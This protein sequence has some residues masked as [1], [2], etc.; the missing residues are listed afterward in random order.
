[1]LRELDPQAYEN[2][3]AM[4][5]EFDYSL[6]IRAALAGNSP[7]RIFVDH[8]DHPKVAFA[9][10][11]EGYLLGGDCE[12]PACRSSVQ[13]FWQEQVFTGKVY[14]DDAT[15]MSLAVHPAGWEHWLPVLIPTHEVEK[16]D[17]YHYLCN[18]LCFDWRSS[19]PSGYIVRRFDRSLLDDPA[20]NLGDSI[21]DFD[22]IDIH[23][24]SLDH[25]LTSGVGFCVLTGNQVASWCQ[26]DCAAGNQID[27]GIE[28]HPQH[29]RRGLATIATAATVEYCL[30]NGYQAVG[31]HCNAINQA[32]W[33]TAQ[34]VGF[35]RDR[36]YAY[37][38][39]MFD[40]LDHL[41]E[42]GWFFYQRGDHEK[43]RQYYE[44]VFSARQDN[45]VEYY[46]LAARVWA[47]VGE[48][49]KA[50]EYLSAAAQRGCTDYEHTRSVEAYK[51]LHATTAWSTILKQMEN[52]AQ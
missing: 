49:Q 7:G 44:R 29:R 35:V 11:I 15:N 4:F 9:M 13:R 28:T 34:K 19:L 33:K 25:F 42:R 1:M 2:A 48:S 26:A 6:S 18:T 21:I 8:P 40:E 36:E 27:I 47:E 22:L 32:S 10:T 46:Q 24:G 51:F 45:P 30:A 14:L 31:W 16:L 39:Y 43:T 52:N 5:Q 37:F 12:D 38:Y 50:L 23:W 17:R 3:C 20:V 41:A